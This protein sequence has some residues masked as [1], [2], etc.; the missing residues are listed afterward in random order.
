MHIFK[1]VSIREEKCWQKW[2]ARNAAAAHSAQH[3]DKKQ[4]PYENNSAVTCKQGE[5]MIP[6]ELTAKAKE[7]LKR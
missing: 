1:Q 5:N 6:P 2:H 4:N 3:S 7:P